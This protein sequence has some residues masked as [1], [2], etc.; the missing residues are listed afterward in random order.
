L[1]IEAQIRCVGLP[2]VGGL[3]GVINVTMVSI[4]VAVLGVCETGVS[5]VSGAVV[6]QPA[7]MMRQRTTTARNGCIVAQSSWRLH[8]AANFQ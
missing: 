3:R 7:S 4:G 2:D 8:N 5:I 1:V 6:V